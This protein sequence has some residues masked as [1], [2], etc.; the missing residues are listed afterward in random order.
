MY[1]YCIVEQSIPHRKMCFVP[2]N[3]VVL[4]N[5]IFATVDKYPS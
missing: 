1:P 5:T 2:R 4:E 3:M